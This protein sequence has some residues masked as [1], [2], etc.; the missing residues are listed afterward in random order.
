[1]NHVELS[2]MGMHVDGRSR[3]V[4]SAPSPVFFVGVNGK[5]KMW[6]KACSETFGYGREMLGLPFS[7]LLWYIDDEEELQKRVRCVFEENMHDDVEII[8]K[9]R[10]SEQLFCISHLYPLVDDRGKVEYCVFSNTNVTE[11]VLAEEKMKHRLNI[12]RLVSTISSRFVGVYEVE[13]AIAATLRD[14]GRFSRASRAYIFRFRENR[15]IMD[16]THEWCAEGVAPQKNTLQNLSSAD[17]PWWMNMLSSGEYI[18]IK[19]VSALPEEASSVREVLAGQDIKSLLVIGFS[20]EGIL[21]GFIGLDNVVGDVD[22]DEGDLALLRTVSEIVG[23]ALEKDESEQRVRT[24]LKEKEILLGEIHHRVKNNL[25]VVSSLLDLSMLHSDNPH[26]RHILEDARSKVNTMAL[27]HTHLYQ[28]ARFDRINIAKVLSTLVE[29]LSC[30]YS[31]AGSVDTLIQSSDVLLNIDQAIPC[32]LVLNELISNAFKHAF[33]GR[34]SGT[35]E[36]FIDADEVGGVTVCLRD[37]GGGIPPGIELDSVKTLGLTL[38]NNLVKNQLRGEILMRR[39][40]GTEY[41]IR[42]NRIDGESLGP[43]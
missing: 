35:I 12:E 21:S 2:T 19:D 13:R 41:S 24:S 23:N 28:D 37:N 3:C 18:H 4:R 11:W 10:Q 36:V 25:Q 9:S 30:V 8:F 39:N 14:L 29:Q 7:R 6:S 43:Q 31:T 17:F 22:W 1:M 33:R 27:I 38:V 32:A 20:V 34:S 40:R 5:V 15:T 16:N 42:F 26:T